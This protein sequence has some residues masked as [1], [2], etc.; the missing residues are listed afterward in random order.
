MKKLMLTLVFVFAIGTSLN[1]TTN[2][3]LKATCF[4]YADAV[5]SYEG[6]KWGLSYD[7]EFHVFEKYYYDCL[8]RRTMG[9]E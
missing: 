5:A 3:T 8:L 9:W 7:E 6:R 2:I 4:E 1:A